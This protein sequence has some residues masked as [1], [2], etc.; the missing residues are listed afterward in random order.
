M[1]APRIVATCTCSQA[2]CWSARHR[3]FLGRYEQILSVAEGVFQD[4]NISQRWLR[5]PVPGLGHLAPCTLIHTA[6]GF[7]EAHNML[8][9]IDHGICI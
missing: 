1:N 7:S 2:A 5:R 3:C 9:R 4:R 6:T 8:M